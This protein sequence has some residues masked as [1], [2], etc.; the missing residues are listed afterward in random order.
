M[1]ATKKMTL[2]ESASWISLEGMSLFT[3]EK[4]ARRI[5]ALDVKPD[6]LRELAKEVGRNP[7]RGIEFDD[8]RSRHK[9]GYRASTLRLAAD[10]IESRSQS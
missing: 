1:S 5:A 8:V 4:T 3:Y 2:I 7:S 9:D 6:E 10:L